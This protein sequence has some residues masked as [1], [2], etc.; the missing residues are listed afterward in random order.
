[1]Q[2]NNADKEKLTQLARYLAHGVAHEQAGNAVGFSASRVSQLLT[3][4]DFQTILRE[5]MQE[6]VVNYIDINTAYDRIEKKALQNLELNARVNSDPDFNMRLALLANRAN[7][8]GETAVRPNR[9]ID[10]AGV[11]GQRIAIN[12]SLNFVKQIQ[13][14]PMQATQ[15][16]TVARTE[17]DVATPSDV[18]NLLGIQVHGAGKVEGLVPDAEIQT[19][20]SFLD[21]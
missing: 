2:V 8:K 20:A 5:Q 7:R 11:D 4:E 6:L 16:V 14:G 19:L 15:A 1:M 13:S 12:L 10:A 9:P 18:S 3:E 21:T 17:L